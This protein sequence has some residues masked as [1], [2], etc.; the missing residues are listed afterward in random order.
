MHDPH[1][2][3]AAPS[4]STPATRARP[5]LQ[6]APHTRAFDSSLALLNEGYRFMPRRFEELGSDIFATRIMLR[7][8]LCMRGA[9]AARLFYASDRFTRRKAIP[10]T[11]LTLLQDFGSAEM[12]DGA[13]H[14][15]RK[16]LM[17]SLL[18]AYDNARLTALAADLWRARFAEWRQRGRVVLLRE[19]ES[20]LAEAACRWAGIALAPE[21]LRLRTEEFAAM[22]DGAG[23][24]GPRNLRAQLLRRRSE[25]WARDLVDAVRS[26][27][28]TADPGSALAVIARHR[29]H[30]G[31]ALDTS[32][33]AVE[34]INLL[35]PTLAVARFVV[36]GALALHQF[37]AWR[38]RLASGDD[39]ELTMFAQEVRR[40]YPFFPG[41]G[42]RASGDFTWHGMRFAKGDWVLLDLYGTNHHPALWPQPESFD[43][44]RFASWRDDGHSLVAQGAGDYLTG[45]RCPGEMATVAL[46][47]SA[48]HLLAAE[49]SYQVPAQDL[50]IDMARMPTMPRSGLVLDVTG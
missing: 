5:V 18:G 44:E 32:T 50:T 25:R 4:T 2:R 36:F 8:V 41:V 35:R 40:F 11:V 16:A 42:G 39:A 20:V 10:P 22:V 43:P 14:L 23:S 24:F 19:A 7:R 45:H 37:P 1:D 6:A 48:L 33:A 15:Q 13:A 31:Q 30:D 17:L 29:D 12:L 47:K 27:R 34:L 9:E 46:M 28:I 21:A 26:G 38:A 3:S 49:A